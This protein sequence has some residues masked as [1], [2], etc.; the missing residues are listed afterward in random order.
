MPPAER[1]YYTKSPRPWARAI[2]QANFRK[3]RKIAM[4]DL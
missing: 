3:K 1:L 4:I 2:F